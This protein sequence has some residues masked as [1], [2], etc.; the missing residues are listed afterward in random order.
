MQIILTSLVSS[1]SLQKKIFKIQLFRLISL[2]D[3]RKMLPV[4][5]NFAENVVNS[6]MFR[7]SQIEPKSKELTEI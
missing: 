3:W 4:Q 2:H 6:P 5:L 1:W 7:G